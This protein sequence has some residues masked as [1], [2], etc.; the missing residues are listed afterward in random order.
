MVF[1]IDL[2]DGWDWTIRE[3]RQR[4]E[5][6]IEL[7]DPDLLIMS[8][9]C[10]PLSRLQACTPMAKGDDRLAL[11]VGLQTNVWNCDE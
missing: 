10:G 1:G 6:A 7:G 2:S 8:P 4:A 3:H 5:M 11:Q 9:P